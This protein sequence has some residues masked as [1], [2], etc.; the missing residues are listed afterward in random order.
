M[1]YLPPLQLR[2]KLTEDSNGPATF[3]FGREG[4][5]SQLEGLANLEV[6][7]LQDKTRVIGASRFSIDS[8]SD[9]HVASHQFLVLPCVHRAT[10]QVH[11]LLHT[12]SDAF[13]VLF[14][15]GFYGILRPSEVSFLPQAVNAQR[16]VVDGLLLSPPSRL[17]LFNPSDLHN[18]IGFLFYFFQPR[19]KSICSV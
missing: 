18:A 7:L 14:A 16:F 9:K 4:R 3:P 5:Q 2:L 6:Y 13:T 10:P 12:T 8:T 11:R 1:E 17:D 15:L 19:A